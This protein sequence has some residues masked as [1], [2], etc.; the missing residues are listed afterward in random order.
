MKAGWLGR[1]GFT[2]FHGCS[3]AG[4]LQLFQ[5][6]ETRWVKSGAVGEGVTADF[7]RWGWVGFAAFGGHKEARLVFPVSC[8]GER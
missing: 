3:K 2:T 8:D 1:V 6:M 4:A 7:M 5:M